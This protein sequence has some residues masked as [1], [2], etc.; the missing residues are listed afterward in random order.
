MRQATTKIGHLA[1]EMS[2]CSEAMGSLFVQCGD[3]HILDVIN[4]LAGQTNLFQPTTG[5]PARR[6]NGR[7]FAVVADEA[8]PGAADTSF[9]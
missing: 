1:Q 6:A 4:T 2:G 9:H 7:G 3:R 8:P 5:A